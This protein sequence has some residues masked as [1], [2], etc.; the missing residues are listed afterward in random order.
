MT[1][2]LP[3]HDRNYNDAFKLERND[4]YHMPVHVMVKVAKYYIDLWERRRAWEIELERLKADQLEI[5]A[6]PKYETDAI[7]NIELEN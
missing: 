7:S 1:V 6:M 4:L 3:K 5:A 2:S